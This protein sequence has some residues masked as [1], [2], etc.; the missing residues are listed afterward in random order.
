MRKLIG[1]LIPALAVLA[2]CAGTYEPATWSRSRGALSGAGVVLRADLPA[3][4]QAPVLVAKVDVGFPSKIAVH[5]AVTPAHPWRNT[6]GMQLV[7]EDSTSDAADDHNVV[8]SPES[9]EVYEG[10]VI[11]ITCN[12]YNESLVLAHTELDT[13]VLD[14]P[15]TLKAWAWCGNELAEAAPDSGW[16][17]AAADT[18]KYDRVLKDNIGK[19]MMRYC[20][21]MRLY[22]DSLD[23]WYTGIRPTGKIEDNGTWGTSP[24]SRIWMPMVWFNMT[25]IPEY[26]KIVRARLVMTLMDNSGCDCSGAGYFA[27][28]LD[29]HAADLPWTTAPGLVRISAG[30]S[31]SLYARVTWN[32]MVMATDTPWSPPL[33]DRDDWHDYGPIS[34]HNFRYAFANPGAGQP[35]HALWLD[36]TDAVQQYCDRGPDRVN[37]GFVLYGTFAN[38]SNGFIVISAGRA[39]SNVRG[40]PQLIVEWV[41]GL[42]NV[43]AW[44]VGGVPF[45]ITLDDCSTDHVTMGAGLDSVGF[46]WTEVVSNNNVGA[47][48]KLT[49]AQID[50]QRLAG[51]DMALHTRSHAAMGNLET[52]QQFFNQLGHGWVDSVWT[53]AA[54]V[55][56]AAVQW[57]DFAYP[58]GGG[59][60]YTI[61]GIQQLQQYGYRSGRGYGT[62]TD[63]SV[64]V[65]THLKWDA[66]SNIMAYAATT[67]TPFKDD[68]YAATYEKVM[69]LVDSYYNADRQAVVLMQH[70]LTGA[71]EHFTAPQWSLFCRVLGDV[72]CAPVVTL[73]QLITQR[74]AASVFVTP[75]ED[76]AAEFYLTGDPWA[77]AVWLGACRDRSTTVSP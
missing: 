17:Y 52:P 32:K 8:F 41:D 43:P 51:V 45:A 33:E 16:T 66:P 40:S 61:T 71:L 77:D 73:E 44:G 55:D 34:E 53:S 19:T 48:G 14:A 60:A 35:T 31:D 38:W 65:V 2:L 42:Y 67:G 12:I 29:T 18:S 47:A 22:P 10:D 36:V 64:G 68:T 58:A 75:T 50:A 74:Y 20:A 3:S 39:L 6:Y 69:T 21:P 57:A 13:V 62:S 37:A 72:D 63:D 11:E 59:L 15:K 25:E 76:F 5:A 4:R 27:A 24:N 1:L 49:A 46:N 56:T 28:R 70:Y 54:P 7:Y 26:A 23:Q 9:W 30:S